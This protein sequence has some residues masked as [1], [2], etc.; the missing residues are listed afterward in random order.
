MTAPA[1]PKVLRSLDDLLTD[2]DREAL[3]QDLT[4]MARLRRLAEDAARE[5]VLP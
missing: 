5:W 2:E 4:E 1:E 3:H